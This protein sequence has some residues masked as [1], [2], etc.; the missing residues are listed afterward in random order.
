MMRRMGDGG[1]EASAWRHTI[2]MPQ[3]CVGVD[4]VSLS[5]VLWFLL[6]LVQI[7]DYL[8]EYH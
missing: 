2:A 5:T 3:V 1:R 6:I 8:E 7:V 4:T